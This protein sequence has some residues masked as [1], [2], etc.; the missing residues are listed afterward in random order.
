MQLKDVIRDQAGI[1]Q[2]GKDGAVPIILKWSPQFESINRIIQF[3]QERNNHNQ[4]IYPPRQLYSGTA[5]ENIQSANIH[6]NHSD[7]L[8]LSSIEGAELTISPNTR[9]STIREIK[10]STE[11]SRYKLK[12]QIIG[13]TPECSK[14]WVIDEQF[15]MRVQLKDYTGQL[16]AWLCGEDAVSAQESTSENSYI[17]FVQLKDNPNHQIIL[18]IAIIVTKLAP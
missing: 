6:V 10:R 16:E 3:A 2:F 7:V 9:Y 8:H 15:I 14:F 5:S 17:D 13:I 18:V 11:P 1:S 12:C 4:T